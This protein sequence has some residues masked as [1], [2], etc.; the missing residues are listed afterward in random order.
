L[1][2]PL[3]MKHVLLQVMTDDLPQ[4]SLILA[5]LEVYSPDFRALHDDQ[6]PNI[7]GQH[8]RSLYNQ[9]LS[10]L[11]KISRHIELPDR[12]ELNRLH[13]ISEEELNHS[14]EWLGRVWERCS[15]FEE[16]FHR[17]KDEESM[18]NQLQEA[19]DNF[20]ELNIDLGLLQGER[21]FI[22]IHVGTVPR[23]NVGQLKEA[24]KLANYLLFNYKEHANNAHVVVVGPKGGRESDLRLVLDTAGFRP[25]SLPPELHD[26]PEK[27]RQELQQRRKELESRLREE[28]LAMEACAN[29]L[30]KQLEDARS[31]LILA[32]PFVRIDSA[33]RSAGHVSIISG[34]IP[35]REIKR[36][37]QAL[38]R[39]LSNP[40][41]IE[42]RSPFPDE[43]PLVPSYMPSN[44]LMKPFATLVKQYG[45]PRYG[46]IDP[47][48]LFTVTFII[49]FGMMFGDIG[50]GLVIVLAAWL[51]RRKLKSF[52]L[53]AICIGLS[54]TLFGVL[55]GSLFGYEGLFHAVW[56][57]PLSD[58]IYMLTVALKWGIGFLLL[59]T[60]ISIYNRFVLGD[61]TRAV[62]DNNG[63]VSITLYLSVIY[64]IYGLYNTGWYGIPAMVIGILALLILLAYKLIETHAP[65][66]ERMLVAFIETL[67][68]VTAYASN[69][70]SFLRVAAFSLNHA[71]LA[72]AVFTLADM[73]SSTHGHVI[74]VILGNTFILVLEG[75][76]VTIQA[77]RLEYYEGFSRFYSG[78][79]IE[80]KPLRLQGAGSP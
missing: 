10:R 77:L 21:M 5:E 65:P 13:V 61:F 23:S 63:L 30:R 54:A 32:E 73:M 19:L 14:N 8:F 59:V 22:D 9:A 51:A 28:N 75:A 78:D 33:A 38:A 29:E 27:I 24:I 2:S 56:I 18:I 76:I 15:A 45:V 80:F 70:L 11:G 3:P 53:F 62:F 6:F 58:P 66:G 72:I 4:A 35:A 37:R 52:T 26:E 42:T 36:T 57:S 1:F 34:W 44:P 39:T 55:Y 41:N 49:M 7:P 31:T 67:E 47:T 12:I 25:L 60:G 16:S 50:H 69:T 68:T 17:L 79:G 46:E 48:A 64:G 40:F 43:R 74:T 20:A 71:A